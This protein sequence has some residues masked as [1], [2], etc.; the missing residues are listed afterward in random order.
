[1][2]EVQWAKLQTNLAVLQRKFP[3]LLLSN[4]FLWWNSKRV[5]QILPRGCST[6]KEKITHSQLHNTNHGHSSYTLCLENGPLVHT[7]ITTII[8][9]IL[10]IPISGEFGSET[11]HHSSI[12]FR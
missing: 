12:I 2:V 8:P 6:R 3:N 1:V 4:W 7:R 9:L 10:C 11:A 5:L